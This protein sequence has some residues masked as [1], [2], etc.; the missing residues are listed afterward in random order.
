V[1]RGLEIA[2]KIGD[3]VKAVPDYRGVL[4]STKVPPQ[5]IFLFDGI[6]I[7]VDMQF[8][9]CYKIMTPKGEIIECLEP[10]LL[11]QSLKNQKLKKGH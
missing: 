5:P 4:G 2:F 9:N 7:I 10:E 8:P 1:I 11:I 3:L 6:G